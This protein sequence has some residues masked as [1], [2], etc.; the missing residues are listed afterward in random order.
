RLRE[1]QVEV[2][3]ALQSVRAKSAATDVLS[4]AI[5]SLR[6]AARQHGVQH[7]SLVSYWLKKWRGTEIEE[8]LRLS[9]AESPI[10]LSEPAEEPTPVPET[11]SSNGSSTSSSALSNA[12]LEHLDSCRHIRRAAAAVNQK[13]ES[14]SRSI[15]YSRLCV[16]NMGSRADASDEDDYGDD[17]VTQLTRKGRISSADVYYLGPVTSNKVHAV[18][19]ERARVR[20]EADDEKKKRASERA[21]QQELLAVLHCVDNALKKEHTKLKNK[22]A[23]MVKLFPDL[24]ADGPVVQSEELESDESNDSEEH[25]NTEFTMVKFVDACR[26]GRTY[27]LR[28]RWKGFESEDDTWEPIS[29]LRA[30]KCDRVDSYIDELKADGLCPPQKSWRDL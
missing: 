9:T 20:K 2:E 14:M 8:A 22:A 12:E 29:A 27:K 18:L 26:Y 4:G 13:Y 25:E 23:I 17:E 24:P 28:A 15:D 30:T 19:A 3:E 7:S 16:A 6:E 10:P 21:Q 5:P 11:S 1:R